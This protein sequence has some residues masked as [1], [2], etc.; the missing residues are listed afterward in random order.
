MQASL[1][2]GNLELCL[3]YSP[4]YSVSDGYLGLFKQDTRNG[5]LIY[6][7]KGKVKK[8]IGD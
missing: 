5:P 8:V 1:A 3:V 6:F 7:L 2:S 4:L